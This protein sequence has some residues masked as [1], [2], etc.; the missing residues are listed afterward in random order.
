MDETKVGALRTIKA[1]QRFLGLAN[2]I[3]D[4]F[5]HSAPSPYRR[6]TQASLGFTCEQNG[7]VSQMIYAFY[8]KSGSLNGLENRL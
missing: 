5:V 1:L 2:F 8:S 7:G 3:E 4:L 6:H